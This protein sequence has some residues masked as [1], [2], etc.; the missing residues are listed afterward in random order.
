MQSAFALLSSLERSS[1][2]RVNSGSFQK[3]RM[4]HLKDRK[5]IFYVKGKDEIM[6]EEII[7]ERDKGFVSN[8]SYDLW[9][10]VGIWKTVS[11]CSRCNMQKS[12]YFKQCS[13][14]SNFYE[15]KAVLNIISLQKNLQY[16]QKKHKKY[17]D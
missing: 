9:Q 6:K 8:I 7:K 2:N 1:S 15:E 11:Y 14:S 17:S 12:C 13:F 5:L 3:F 10:K 4:W 16:I